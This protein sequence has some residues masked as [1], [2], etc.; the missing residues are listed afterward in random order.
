[1]SNLNSNGIV[2][3]SQQVVLT[4]L[5]LASVGFFIWSVSRLFRFVSI[6]KPSSDPVDNFGWRIGSVLKDFFG[7]KNPC[8]IKLSI[9]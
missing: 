2:M 8:I 9:N 7:I 3:Q 6:G 4:V 5:I 1:M